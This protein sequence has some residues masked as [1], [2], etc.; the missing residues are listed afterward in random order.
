MVQ[1]VSKQEFQYRIVDLDVGD[2]NGDGRE[3]LIV[4]APNRVIV[5]DYRNKRLKQVAR[6]RAENKNHQ[7]L[8]VDVG[9]INRN[10][11]D[12]IFVTGRFDNSLSSFVLEAGPGKKRLKKTWDEVNLYFRI[13]HPFGTRPTLLAQAPGSNDPFHGPI[14]R[15]IYRK[16]RYRTHSKLKLPEVH[17]TEFILYGLTSAD[18]N[19]DRKREILLLDKNYKLRVY[20][21][22]GRVRVQ[23][24]EVYGRDPRSFDL[25]VREEAG[26]VVQ[27]GEPVPYRGRLQLIRQGKN[28]YLLLPKNTSTGGALLPGLMLDTHGSITFLKLTPEGFEKTSEIKKQKGTLRPTVS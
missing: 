8:G 25:G 20:S 4:I 27:E 5:Y 12:E 14:S 19:G 6:F 28:R 26:G 3:E 11:R 15:M 18:I 24:E 22:S 7:F 16:G 21:A 10:G 23:S 13:I 2:I 1:Y 17:G 9:D